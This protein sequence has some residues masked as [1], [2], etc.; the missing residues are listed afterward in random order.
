MQ[1]SMRQL[2]EAG[3][4]IKLQPAPFVHSKILL[5][6]NQYSLIGSANIDQRSL[7]L[8]FEFNVETY[9]REL[10]ATLGRHVA[11]V[12]ARSRSIT[13]DEVDSRSLPVRLRDGIARLFSPYL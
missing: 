5:I 8:N 12:I 2:L 10:C 13:L 4:E 9:D 6:D 3:I 11:G 1:N 7:R